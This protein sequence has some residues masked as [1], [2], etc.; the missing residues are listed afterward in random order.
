MMAKDQVRIV[1]A[2]RAGLVDRAW[3]A[4]INALRSL[5]GT[6]R[7]GVE[8]EPAAPPADIAV[9]SVPAA[10]VAMQGA[11]ARSSA[12]GAP[13]LHAAEPHPGLVGDESAAASK[14][15]AP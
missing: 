9:R 7:E 12:T 8:D 1:T 14:G 2:H 3:H 10:P 4:A 13:P 5:T 15:E 11:A 6:R